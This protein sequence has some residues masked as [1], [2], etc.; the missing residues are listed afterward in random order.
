MSRFALRVSPD[1]RG[2]QIFYIRHGRT[3]IREYCNY[4]D[5]W[6]GIV[7]HRLPER[8][9]P[10]NKILSFFFFRFRL[11]FS[12]FSSFLANPS[13]VFSILSCRRPAFFSSS[14]FSFPFAF[15]FSVFLLIS[16]PYSS[17]A[18]FF[19]VFFLKKNPNVRLRY[20]ASEQKEEI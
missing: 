13:I 11:L 15:F 12:F 18:F 20:R 4:L 17:P 10:W 2:N 3:M 6:C 8:V 5:A 9:L 16:F 19:L 1:E 7:Q 14:S